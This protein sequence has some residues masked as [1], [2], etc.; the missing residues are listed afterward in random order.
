MKLHRVQSSRH[1]GPETGSSTTV[2]ASHSGHGVTPFLRKLCWHP[3]WGHSVHGM[4]AFAPAPGP[5]TCEAYVPPKPFVY[6]LL[7]SLLRTPRC[8]QD[9]GGCNYMLWERPLP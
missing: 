3:M 1:L 7:I 8:A 4:P 9:V 5:A 6:P 2:P